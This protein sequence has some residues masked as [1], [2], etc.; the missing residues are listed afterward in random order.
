MQDKSRHYAPTRRFLIP[1]ALFSLL[2]CRALGAQGT[3]VKPVAATSRNNHYDQT[4]KLWFSTRVQYVRHSDRSTVLRQQELHPK[5]ADLLTQILD[6][7]TEREVFL[8]PL[9]RSV[10]TLAL[11]RA[12]QESLT[13]GAW[14][15][16]CPVE[17]M[18]NASPGGVF[19]GHQT[20]HITKDWGAGEIAE[21]WMILELDCFTV[22]EI[23]TEADGQYSETVV[24]SLHEGEPD[25]SFVA[26][27]ADCAERSPAAVD[28]LLMKATG[29]PAFGCAWGARMEREYQRHKVR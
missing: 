14:E 4:G 24:E 29:E 16:S 18:A 2:A 7:Q 8:E 5:K 19:F 22:K 21:R 10:T 27:P 17:D 23:N 26:V 13:S 15:G 9:T 25:R 1:L 6:R 20:L 3:P 12:E 11:S 28:D